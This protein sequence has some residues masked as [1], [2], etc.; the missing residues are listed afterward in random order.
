MPPTIVRTPARFSPCSSPKNPPTRSRANAVAMFVS[1]SLFA[2][3][4]LSGFFI[5]S[6]LYR[7][8]CRHHMVSGSAV[9]VTYHNVLACFMERLCGFLDIAGY[10]HRV[11]VCVRH[12]DPVHYVFVRHSE[13][14]FSAFWHRNFTRFILE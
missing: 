14:H 13:C 8:C 12:V 7:N 5:V 4:I 6:L 3:T 2:V 1:A 9:F 10:D 11:Q